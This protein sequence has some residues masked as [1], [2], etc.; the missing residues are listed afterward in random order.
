MCV[1]DWIS[2]GDECCGGG[3]VVKDDACLQK[4]EKAKRIGFEKMVK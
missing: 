2:F 1:D 3:V 4:R